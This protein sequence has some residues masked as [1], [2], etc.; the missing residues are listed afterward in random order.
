[1]EK[2]GLPTIRTQKI[3]IILNPVAILVSL[4][5]NGQIENPVILIE[6]TINPKCLIT[7]P[8]FRK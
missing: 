4:L 6:F 2:S 1:M 5:T 8:I 7:K 3:N